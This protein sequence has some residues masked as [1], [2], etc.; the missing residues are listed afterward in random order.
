MGE[1]AFS[2]LRRALRT[3]QG[4]SPTMPASD[5]LD[6]LCDTQKKGETLPVTLGLLKHH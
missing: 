4:C 1:I 2:V 6:N 3:E 5:S